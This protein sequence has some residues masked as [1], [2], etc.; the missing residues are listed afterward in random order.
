MQGSEGNPHEAGHHDLHGS[1]VHGRLL[2]ED[3]LATRGTGVTGQDTQHQ[4]PALYYYYIRGLKQSSPAKML[5]DSN[6]KG[7]ISGRSIHE[8]HSK[9]AV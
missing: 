9:R 8:N 1:H 2:L 4:L 7:E 6:S 3:A 5:L